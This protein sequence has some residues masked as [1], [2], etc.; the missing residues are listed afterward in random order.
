M[1]VGVSCNLRVRNFAQPLTLVYAFCET[2]WPR[3]LRKHFD[4]VHASRGLWA[5]LV[6]IFHLFYYFSLLLTVG[7]MKTNN[8]E[9]LYKAKKMVAPTSKPAQSFLLIPT[10]VTLTAITPTLSV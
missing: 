9:I 8:R 2:N 4:G 3:L 10:P 7:Q 5:D 1:Y 6:A